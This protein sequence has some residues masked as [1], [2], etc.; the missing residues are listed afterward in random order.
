MP[1]VCR[2][3]VD[4]Y[5]FFPKLRVTTEWMNTGDGTIGEVKKG[6]VYC[7]SVTRGGLN[8]DSMST[9]FDVVFSGEHTCYFKSIGLQ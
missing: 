3:M 6:A 1:P 7:V 4:M 8:G 9:T 5:K 2:N